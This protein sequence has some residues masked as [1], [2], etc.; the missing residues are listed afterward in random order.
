MDDRT[1]LP[2][3]P[4]SSA[5]IE[6][7]SGFRAGDASGACGLA[8]EV[9][10]PVHAIEPAPPRGR[11]KSKELLLVCVCVFVGAICVCLGQCPVDLFPARFSVLVLS[12]GLA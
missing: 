11:V 5:R 1:S 3:C 8:A 12:W 4:K 6:P 2:L 10:D 9:A 7:S